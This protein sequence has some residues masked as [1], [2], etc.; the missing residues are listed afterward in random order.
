MPLI[1][2]LRHAESEA[3]LKGILA[4][5]DNSVNLTSKG[6]KDA[7]KVSKVLSK[8]DF[9]VIYSSPIN[10]CQQTIEPL[11]RHLTDKPVHLS[12]AL[13]EMDYGSWSGKYLK[14]LSSK[15]EWSLIQN[16]PAEFTFPKGE[17]F[18]S[19]RK[20]VKDLLTSLANSQGPILLVSHGDVI[21]MALT[22]ALDLPLN[23]FQNFAVAPASISIINYS[24]DSKSVVSLNNSLG[25]KSLF[26]RSSSFIL[27]GGRG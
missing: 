14:Q 3:N 6:F 26:K 1:Y 4:G 20:R 23:K 11:L 2:L 22:L 15:K 12:D 19:M 21:K 7:R 27:G 24:R 5:R 9:E 16:Q 18:L 10:R 13:I 17:S 25:S 8:I